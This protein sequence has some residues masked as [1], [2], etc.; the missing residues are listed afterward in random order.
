MLRYL[1][2]SCMLICCCY[3]HIRCSLNLILIL[4]MIMELVGN[5]NVSLHAML[6]DSD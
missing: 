2:P 1:K 4:N 3:V 6:T 5:R